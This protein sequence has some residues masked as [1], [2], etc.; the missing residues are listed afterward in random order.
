MR[1]GVD[2]LISTILLVALV[3][4]LAA[5]I[6]PWAF[7][8]AVDTTNQTTEETNMQIRCQNAAYDVDTTYGTNGFTFD[9]STASDI[10]S[11]RIVN[12]GLVN[13]YNF[14]FEVFF[15]SSDEGLVVKEL[16]MND[17]FQKTKALPLKPGASAVLRA[18][19]TEDLNG[20]LQKVKVRNLACPSVFVESDV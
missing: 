15:N 17:T 14:S 6:S 20:T 4:A 10:L 9:I 7:N 8:L 11:T 2:P 3:V 5:F 1:K 18:I 13:M 19:F 16:S 12:T